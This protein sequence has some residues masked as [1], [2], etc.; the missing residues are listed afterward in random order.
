VWE[1]ISRRARRRKM[2]K[3]VLG[4]AAGVIV[5]AGAVPAVIAVRHTSDNQSLKIGQGTGAGK[6][7]SDQSPRPV[8]LP[9]ESSLAGFFPESVSFISQ[10][11]GFLYGSSGTSSRAVIAETTDAGRTWVRRPAPPVRDAFVSHSGR[12][13][14]QIRFATDGTGFLFGSSYWVSHDYGQTWARQPFHGYIDALETRNG[15]VWALARTAAQPHLVSLYTATTADPT[16]RRVAAVTPMR[17]RRGIPSMT[18]TASLA[19]SANY[20][21][22]GTRVVAIVGH[23][24]LWF[25]A[26]G[27][28][29]VEGDDP[30]QGNPRSTLVAISGG[31]DVVAACGYGV[32]QNSQVKRT[33]VSSDGGKTWKPTKQQPAAAGYLETLAAGTATSTIV[34]TSRGGAQLSTN[35]GRTWSVASPQQ[36]L[37]LSFIGYINTFYIVGVANRDGSATGTSGAFATSTDNGA[38]WTVT[39]FPPQSP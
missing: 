31:A 22:G 30:C 3:A 16:L 26:T 12:G 10:Y 11:Q 14:G 2:A 33:F 36:G 23:S 18:G 25:S 28:R 7:P 24:G 21:G 32:K 17:G 37:K 34:G 9:S 20:L 19:V 4:A 27:R 38:S 1:T 8:T 29:W 39:Q 15:Q 6:L 5:L 13:I 35:A